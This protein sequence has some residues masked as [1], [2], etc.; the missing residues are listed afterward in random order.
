MKNL[1]LKKK[2]WVFILTCAIFSISANATQ[3][4]IP[5]SADSL[6]HF[7]EV[8]TDLWVTGDTIVLTD[9]NYVVNG[10]MDLYQGVVIIGDPALLPARPMVKLNDN[11]FRFKQ[12]SIGITIKGIDFDGYNEENGKLAFALVRSDNLSVHDSIFTSII[13][14]DCDISNMKS[15]IQLQKVKWAVYDSVVVNNCIWSNI[16]GDYAIDPRI[17]FAK[18]IVVTN[19]TFYNL[20]KGFL[21]NP[22][23]AHEDNNFAKVPKEIIIDHNTFYNIG[24]GNNALIQINDPKDSTINLSFTNN[25]VEKLYDPANVRPFRIDPS[26][27]T[28]VFDHNVIYDFMP[29]EESKMAYSFDTLILQT[30]VTSTNLITDDPKLVDVGDFRLPYTSAL[31]TADS[32]G[33][34][35]GDPRWGTLQG[36]Y[37]YESKEQVYTN[38]PVQLEAAVVIA[39]G[40]TSLNWTLETFY[41]G[42]RGMADIVDSTGLFTPTVAG[43]VK[44][45]ATCVDSVQFFDT[46]VISIQDS[47][48]IDSIELMIDGGGN[49]VISEKEGDLDLLARLY[50]AQP[51][52]PEV[53][54]SV[55]D[56]SLL[57]IKEQPDT[58]TE[59]AAEG[60]NGSVWVYVKTLD[61]GLMDSIQISIINQISVESVEI[62]VQ[63]DA[64]PVIDEV[65]GTLQLIANIA[66]DTADIKDVTWTRYPTNVASVSADGLVTALKEGIV[67]VVV[68]TADG[69]E[70]DTV[71]I[72]IGGLVAH[73]A[74]DEVADSIVTDTVGG[75]H[76]ILHHLKNGWEEGKL[77]NCIH[78]SNGTDTTY[79]EVPSTEK[80]DLD[81]TTSFSISVLVTTSD[82]SGSDQNVMFKGAT[83]DEVDGH[84]Y[85]IMFKE[86]EL[87]F[88]ID[89][90]A[91]KSQLACTDADKKM[92]LDGSWNHIVGV[93][94]LAKDSLYIY[95]NGV[96]VAEMKDNT[97]LNISSQLP[98]YIGQNF[99]GKIDEARIYNKALTADNI[100]ELTTKYSIIA[101]SSDATLSDLLIDGTSISNFNSDT[102]NYTVALSEGTTTVPTVTYTENDVNASAIVNDASAIPGSTTVVVTAEDGSTK[103]Y[104]IE[105]T[106]GT[107]INDVNY[108]NLRI[109][110][111]PANDYIEINVD[112]QS[113]V[114]IFT[115]DG[116]KVMEETIKAN[117]TLNIQKLTR[118]QYIAKVKTV[119]KISTLRFMKK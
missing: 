12:D 111:N 74:M 57:W 47:I 84:W 82:I 45:T 91:N 113:I 14:E 40:D 118:G 110:P 116:K 88:A 69:G 102:I 92:Y 73:W 46:L 9:A 106:I 25:I 7:L 20:D 2:K 55:S 39:T 80:I 86:N 78:F 112:Q 29:T 72:V 11:G 83:S 22:A 42:T 41:G 60:I 52:N 32:E 1:L 28:F 65:D 66:P 109:Y 15:G 81:S 58:I 94:D 5:S 38:A 3:F 4:L 48:H 54:W 62:S 27:G 23:F 105:F 10:T 26:A 77:G 33:G 107:G 97:E 85:A 100:A 98:L 101:K 6:E 114:S 21:K 43:Q 71:E 68:E 75:S 37:I 34:Q 30:N 119:D 18:K 95:L 36:V 61:G 117:G 76:G 53:E 56:E 50:P 87:R 24:A 59:C 90:K 17:C 96:K 19:S 115:I 104:T 63:D 70:T 79:I 99:K 13:V 31:L 108:S 67:N 16:L 35:I 49:P 103:T 64:P 93:R 51:T 44:V 89:D 8:H